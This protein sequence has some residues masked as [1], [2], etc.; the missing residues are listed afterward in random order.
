MIGPKI[1]D[2]LY[3][4][5]HA[6][7]LSAPTM[8]SWTKHFAWLPVTDIH[9]ER[10]WLKTVYRRSSKIRMSTKGLTIGWEYGNIFDVLSSVEPP[11][12]FEDMPSV[13]VKGLQGVQGAQG[14]RGPRGLAGVNPPPKAP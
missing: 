13:G 1:D 2:R 12:E 10:V 7:T 3:Y 8:N 14:I 6:H 4:R 5:P 11:N 9:G